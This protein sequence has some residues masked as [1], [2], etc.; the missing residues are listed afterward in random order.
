MANPS[1]VQELAPC[2]FNLKTVRIKFTASSTVTLWRRMILCLHI[3]HA[4]PIYL[5]TSLGIVLSY[6]VTHLNMISKMHIAISDGHR[7]TIGKF[8]TTILR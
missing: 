6:P 1:P 7:V 3:L 5:E 2:R 8:E 4:A